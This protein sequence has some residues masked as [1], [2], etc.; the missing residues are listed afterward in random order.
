MNEEKD[1]KISKLTARNQLLDSNNRI[2]AQKLKDKDKEIKTINN[3]YLKEKA[4]LSEI[5][6]VVSSS[7]I[8]E[9]NYTKMIDWIK[10]VIKE[11][12]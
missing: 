8:N 5:Y 6:R 10:K 11:E 9:E 2:L 1:E 7:K 12:V 4:K 3:L